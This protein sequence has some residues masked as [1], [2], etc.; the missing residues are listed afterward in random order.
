MIIKGASDRHG[1]GMWRLWVTQNPQQAKRAACL[2]R[3]WEP[4]PSKEERAKE[5]DLRVPGIVL[6]VLEKLEKMD[7]MWSNAASWCAPSYRCR[8]SKDE[9]L[10][11]NLKRR[12]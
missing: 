11:T 2:P 3:F 9:V 4:K 10:K 6:L 7:K 8:S 12:F 5:S 1:G